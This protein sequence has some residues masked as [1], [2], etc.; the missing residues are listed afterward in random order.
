MKPRA[1]P[2]P[3]AIPAIPKPKAIPKSTY[4]TPLG[5][6]LSYRGSHV[7]IMFCRERGAGK[8]EEQQ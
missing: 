8:K 1:I 2:V 7:I 6:C 3:E 5:S 4:V